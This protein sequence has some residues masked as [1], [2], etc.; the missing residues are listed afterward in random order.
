M[1]RLQEL[2]QAKGI[3]EEVIKEVLAEMK[4]NKLYLAG[5]ENLDIRYS[6]LKAQHD[7]LTSQHAELQ[8]LTEELK[9][10]TKGNE[11]LQKKFTDSE[12]RIQALEKELEQSKLE[13]AIK[14]GLL[15]EKV[16]D[17]DYVTFKLKEKGDLSLDENG[18]IKGWQ[19]KIAGL[20]VQLPKQF[21]GSET[22]K[23]E[24][25]KL[26]TGKSERTAEPTSLADAIKMTYEKTN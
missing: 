26:E 19:D 13:A 7:N 17:I 1:K 14:V 10:G 3:S 2:L 20:K 12:A 9:K 8:N 22:K 25:F 24:E 4:T 11:E 16:E 5:E 21:G 15:E 18:K 23:V 6:K